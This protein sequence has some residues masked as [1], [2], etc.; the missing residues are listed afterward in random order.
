MQGGIVMDR[1][2]T[3]H[4]RKIIQRYYDNEP[5]LQLQRLA[6]LVGE[7]YLSEGKKKERLWKSAALALEKLNVPAWRIQHL[8]EKKDPVL[9]AEVVKE[10]QGKAS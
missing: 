8:V 2:Y 7:L 5:N 1:D 4:Q 9:L 6:D 3:P 10:L